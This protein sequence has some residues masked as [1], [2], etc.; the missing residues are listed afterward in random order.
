MRAIGVAGGRRKAGDEQHD[1][2]INEISTLPHRSTVRTPLCCCRVCPPHAHLLAS[3]CGCEW[4]PESGLADHPTRSPSA[5][6]R[7][8]DESND[9]RVIH[10]IETIM[11]EMILV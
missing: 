9:H 7:T 1:Q 5:S 2:T 4:S 8:E 11:A 3:G 10:M 6:K